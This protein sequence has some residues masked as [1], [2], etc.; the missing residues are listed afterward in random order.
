MKNLFGISPSASPTAS[1]INKL[2]PSDDASPE[3]WGTD[4]VTV[5]CGAALMGAG[6]VG[7][8][9]GCEAEGT[10]IGYSPVEQW[11]KQRE[12]LGLSVCSTSHRGGRRENPED[13]LGFPVVMPAVEKVV[14][15]GRYRGDV[16]CWEGGVIGVY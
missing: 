10:V 16:G 4:G 12:E 8:H 15:Y 1:P 14:L 2:D 6:S 3:Q 11:G 9:P 7:G 13:Q 5:V